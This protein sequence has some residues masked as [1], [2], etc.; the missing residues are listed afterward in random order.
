MCVIPFM[1][2][3][4]MY[5]GILPVPINNYSNAIEAT[6]WWTLGLCKNTIIRVL[7]HWTSPYTRNW[8]W[9]AVDCGWVYRKNDNIY[10]NR[11]VMVSYLAKFA[12]REI[13]MCKWLFSYR[14]GWTRCIR[15]HHSFRL[16]VKAAL[17]VN[18]V[19]LNYW[20]CRYFLIS[21]YTKNSNSMHVCNTSFKI[22]F[23]FKSFF[24]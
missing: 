3:F 20:L 8:W 16:K 7:Y 4:L 15:W 10:K 19:M 24:F 1:F 2:L 14:C 5:H 18:W 17:Y 11:V 13:I 6:K 21:W 12:L 9:C 23:I 22:T